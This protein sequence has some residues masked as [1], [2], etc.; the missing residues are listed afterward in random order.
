[1]S[2]RCL[3]VLIKSHQKKKNPF[4]DLQLSK[5]NQ[6]Q[7]MMGAF[8][9]R[10]NTANAFDGMKNYHRGLHPAAEMLCYLR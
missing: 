5:K 6:H 8:G 7:C 4:E 2:V 10:V 9:D 3:F 1:M